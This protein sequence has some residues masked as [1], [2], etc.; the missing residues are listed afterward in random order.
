VDLRPHLCHPDGERWLLAQ[1][2]EA[3]PRTGEVELADWHWHR[4][5]DLAALPAGFRRHFL[6]GLALSSWLQVE[7][8]RAAYDALALESDLQC[9]RA[10]ARL[11]SIADR[12]VGLW[13]C[14]AL[15]ELPGGLRARAAATV[16]GRG[17]HR[18]RPDPEMRRA[19]A[20]GELG[21]LAS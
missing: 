16:L 21:P 7:L 8:T 2:R 14:D 10:V 13:W 5:D 15:A 12:E 19:L 9:R 17:I 4:R 3:L 1:I 18:Q 6:W 11:L 20:R